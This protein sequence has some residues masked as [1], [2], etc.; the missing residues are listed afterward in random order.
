MVGNTATIMQGLH[1]R[2]APITEPTY[3]RTWDDIHRLLAHMGAEMRAQREKFDARRAALGNVPET[4]RALMKYVHARAT[5]E[6]LQWTLG[7]REDVGALDAPIHLVRR[8]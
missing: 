1:A 7:M 5:F 2:F 4:H 3:D 6:C 8:G